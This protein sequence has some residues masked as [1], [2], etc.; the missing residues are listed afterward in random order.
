[1]PSTSARRIE[2][3]QTVT[4]FEQ[5]SQPV[6]QP[7]EELEGHSDDEDE[8]PSKR[9]RTNE[10]TDATGNDIGKIM[11]FKVVTAS[12]SQRKRHRDHDTE[13]DIACDRLLHQQ[14]TPFSYEPETEEEAGRRPR[15]Q[16]CRSTAVVTP[17]TISHTPVAPLEERM[18]RQRS[19]DAMMATALS[20]TQTAIRL[21]ETVECYTP[22]PACCHAIILPLMETAS[23]QAFPEPDLLAQMMFKKHPQVLQPHRQFFIRGLQ[24]FSCTSCH[25]Q[26]CAQVRSDI[27]MTAV[28]VFPRPAK[29]AAA[30]RLRQH[31]KC[32]Y[33]GH[34]PTSNR[35]ACGTPQEVE[36]QELI[37]QTQ[38]PTRECLAQMKHALNVH[39]CA[40]YPPKVYH[41]FMFRE[42]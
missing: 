31:P 26:L 8:E 27:V 13:E 41:I 10:S 9:Q 1:V 15:S 39:D 5:S 19:A 35:C 30:K 25:I 29:A 22:C 24:V 6:A 36:E 37:A 32:P 38:N 7:Q 11:M 17:Y 2:A 42:L 23:L 3:T 16:L 20:R 28:K 18:R 21:Q 14:Y 34:K 4:H 12:N 33:C 40:K